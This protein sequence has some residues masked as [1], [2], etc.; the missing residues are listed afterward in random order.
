VPRA[1]H[2]ISTTSQTITPPQNNTTS[3]A[4]SCGGTDDAEVNKDNMTGGNEKVQTIQEKYEHE[5][6]VNSEEGL[7]RLRGGGWQTQYAQ[8]YSDFDCGGIGTTSAEEEWGAIMPHQDTIT[9]FDIKDWTWILN[10]V[11]NWN[12]NWVFSAR[13]GRVILVVPGYVVCDRGIVKDTTDTDHGVR[14]DTNYGNIDVIRA[15]RRSDSSLAS[16]DNNHINNLCIMSSGEIEATILQLFSWDSQTC[17][18]LI[19]CDQPDIV[20]VRSLNNNNSASD[21]IDDYVDHAI[22]DDVDGYNNVFA[23]SR[24]E[25]M[26]FISDTVSSIMTYGYWG[27]TAISID[28]G[29]RTQNRGMDDYGEREGNGTRLTPRL[30]DMG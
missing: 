28:E 20:R 10:R 4:K 26:I 1:P 15:V 3:D 6:D 12:Y 16:S 13:G 8:S 2:E 19:L 25:A 14:V 7:C 11:K 24:D 30:G 21:G 18:E 23:S 27:D 22:G 9:L 29:Q 17:E 5:K